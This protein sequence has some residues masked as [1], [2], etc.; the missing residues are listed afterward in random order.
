MGQ[1]GEVSKPVQSLAVI[2]TCSC[3]STDYLFWGNYGWFFLFSNVFFCGQ[4]CFWWY[5][6]R[7]GCSDRHEIKKEVYWF[8]V[9]PSMLPRPIPQPTMTLILDCYNPASAK[10]NGVY[11][12]HLVVPVHPSICGQNSDCACIFHNTDWIPF[13]FTHPITQLR[14]VSCVSSCWTIPKFEFLAS[15]L[16]L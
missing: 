2:S 5:L 11:W 10:L 8:N 13:L 1:H 7:N 14:N 3:L 16:I 4:T 15:F 9:Q 6:I 12:F